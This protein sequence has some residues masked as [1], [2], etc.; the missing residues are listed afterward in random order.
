MSKLA[1]LAS[2]LSWARS[3]VRELYRATHHLPDPLAAVWR[4]AA[5]RIALLAASVA[6]IAL[7]VSALVLP[8]I[9]TRPDGVL[10]L[11]LDQWPAMSIRLLAVLRLTSSAWGKLIFAIFVAVTAA[12]SSAHVERALMYSVQGKYE[13]TL[14]GMPQRH[15]IYS[16]NSVVAVVRKLR[17]VLLSLGYRWHG[18]PTRTLSAIVE[19]GSTRQFAL[20]VASAALA[21]LAL[22]GLYSPR[23]V[24]AEAIA[25]GPGSEQSLT[26]LGARVFR[27][28]Q[29]TSA[30]HLSLHPT[31]SGQVATVSLRYRQPAFL[32]ATM[33]IWERSGP[34]LAI[35]PANLQ[36]D[37]DADQ[38]ADRNSR[39]FIMILAG[40]Q[41]KYVTL[42]Q[43]QASLRV[44][45]AAESTASRFIVELLPTEGSGSG[46]TYTISRPT[47]L[48]LGGIL[49][50]FDP[51]NYYVISIIHTPLLVPALAL[52][53]VAGFGLTASFG[54]RRPPLRIGLN[55][56]GPIVA[57]EIE[58]F[59]ANP[60]RIWWLRLIRLA[61][62]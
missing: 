35:E 29:A 45:L 19:T 11:P 42:P 39:L 5:S 32:G 8:G 22:S 26:A 21:L 25:V 24:V 49:L 7:L 2:T 38:A 43:G 31:A 30:R 9:Y 51:S 6:A 15:I 62:R 56:H 47:I 44:S 60:S 4:V 53:L 55:S 36:E 20:A 34:A 54:C 16:D 27:I 14:S 61:L 52:L 1:R 23:T 33:I 37:S 48:S 58:V 50:R 18:S 12:H 46:E 41:I 13:A 59:K 3:Q 40:E 10:G 57:V 17:L 28:E